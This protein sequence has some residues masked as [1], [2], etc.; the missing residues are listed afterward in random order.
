MTL[1]DDAAVTANRALHYLERMIEDYDRVTQSNEFNEVFTLAH[2]HGMGYAG[3]VFDLELL[4]EVRQ[5]IAYHTDYLQD[6]A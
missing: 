4:G 1:E 2:I 3:P 6:P 5:F